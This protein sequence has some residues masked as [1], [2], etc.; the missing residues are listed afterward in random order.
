MNEGLKRL[1]FDYIIFAFSIGDR[2]IKVK[3]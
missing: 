2:W 1:Y 3:W